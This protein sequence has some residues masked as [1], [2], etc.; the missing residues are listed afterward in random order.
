M[1]CGD[2]RLK[3]NKQTQQKQTGNLVIN[4]N[5]QQQT[6]RTKEMLITNKMEF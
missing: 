6:K 3:A 4:I 1:C 5:Q 2:N